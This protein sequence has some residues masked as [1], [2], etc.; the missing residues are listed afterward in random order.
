MYN[1][2]DDPSY[3]NQDCEVVLR[4]IPE[5][6]NAESVEEYVATALPGV[7]VQFV[8]D[9]V[10][11]KNQWCTIMSVSNLE[12]AESVANTLNRQNIDD[13]YVKAHLHPH[14]KST[15]VNKQ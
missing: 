9:P 8:E 12:D 2:N 13:K 6:W 5:A 7:K 4:N 11:I 3:I 10:L 15:R 14:N 1:I